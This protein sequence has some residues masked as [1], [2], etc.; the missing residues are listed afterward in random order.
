MGAE[1]RARWENKAFY[2]SI[3]KVSAPSDDPEPNPAASLAKVNFGIG[4]SDL[5]ISES[6]ASRILESQIG[7]VP[8]GFTSYREKLQSDFRRSLFVKDAGHLTPNVSLP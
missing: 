6:V 1:E 4:E 2:G 7:K 5:P 8:G 3:N